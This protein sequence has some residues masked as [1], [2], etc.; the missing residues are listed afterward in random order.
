MVDHKIQDADGPKYDS[1]YFGLRSDSNTK[2]VA[3]GP[4]S[5]FDLTLSPSPSPSILNMI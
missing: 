1:S 5:P 3:E 2:A 4:K